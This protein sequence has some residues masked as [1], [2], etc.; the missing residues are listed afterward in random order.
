MINDNFKPGFGRDKI[1]KII[2]DYFFLLTKNSL[3][4]EIS[5]V[6]E[7]TIYSYDLKHKE[8]GVGHQFKNDEQ[9]N[10]IK[11]KCRKKPIWY[12][13]V[14]KLESNHHDFQ[15]IMNTRMSLRSFSK[16]N[17][18]NETL[19]EVIDIAK[20][21]PSV[22]NR[23][24]WRVHCLN[25]GSKKNKVLKLQNGCA[26]FSSEINQ[27]IIL[28]SSL[29]FFVTPIER[30]QQYI[31]GGIFLG[32]LIN[33]LHYKNIHSCVLN[34]AASPS[35]DKALHRLDIIPKSESVIA[36]VA[37]GYPKK[38]QAISCLSKRIDTKKVIN[39][40]GNGSDEK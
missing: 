16:E 6:V 9:F 18:K 37:F 30:Y 23:Q 19:L 21:T 36:I 40:H 13:V 1:T 4:Y 33:A 7:D 31:D 12:R 32:N 8:L 20:K 38:G 2:D 10:E 5:K 25:H 17:V 34:W 14:P 26:G 35:N 29:E 3:D 24:H 39:F 28:T 15:E 11:Q 27:I 22:C